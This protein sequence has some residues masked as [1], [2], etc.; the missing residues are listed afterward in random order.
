MK[1]LLKGGRLVDPAS[2][3][4]GIFDVLI[5]RDRIARVGRDLPVE[6]DVTVVEMPSGVIVCPGLIDM[7]VHLREPGQ[8]HKET[9]AT[10][11]AAAVAGGFT[12]VACMPNTNPVN[13]NAGVTEYMLKKAAEANLARVY[14]IGAVSRGQKGEQLA[15]IAELK[16]AGCVAITDDGKPV[17]TALLMRRAL[18]YT[19]MFNM[20]V[21]EH[22]E[23]QTLKGDGVAHDTDAVPDSER[24]RLEDLDVKINVV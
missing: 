7:H 4:D 1:R 6:S 9:V 23:D 13:D 20:P 18:E 22:C 14:P 10:G 17:A 12:A 5:D 24:L 21:I 2:G 16:A 11:T 15:D 3:R 8:E 19:S